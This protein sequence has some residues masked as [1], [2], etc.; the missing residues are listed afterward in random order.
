MEID[1]CLRQHG[2]KVTK[3]RINILDILRKNDR[4]LSAEFI[5]D[6]CKQREINIDL[7]TVYRSLELFEK[8]DIIRKFDLGCGKYNYVIKQEDHKHILQCKVCHKKV[9]IDCP[10]QQI[11]EMIKNTTGFTAVDEELNINLEGI[12]NECKKKKHESKE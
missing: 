3:A 1:H 4:A 12:C 2:I 8:K 9:E 6:E 7:S 11:R 5:F 10:M